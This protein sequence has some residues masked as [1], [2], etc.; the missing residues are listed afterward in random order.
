MSDFWPHQFTKSGKEVQIGEEKLT[1][2]VMRP[3]MAQNM[4][5]VHCGVE[6]VQGQDSPPLPPCPARNDKREMKRIKN[7]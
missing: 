3:V 1:D 2:N 5:C 6:F 7:G 4:V